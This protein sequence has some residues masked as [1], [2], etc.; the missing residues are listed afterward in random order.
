[1]LS[2]IKEDQ[3]MSPYRSRFAYARLPGQRSP[4]ECT[5]SREQ[6]RTTQETPQVGT[7]GP[8]HYVQDTMGGPRSPDVSMDDMWIYD[9]YA[10]EDGVS[11]GGY[12]RSPS[13]PNHNRTISLPTSTANYIPPNNAP[14]IREP[15]HSHRPPPLDMPDREPQMLDPSIVMAMDD[16]PGDVLEYLS[17][18][19]PVI[20]SSV[21]S[22]AEYPE[23]S[24][25]EQE[26]LSV[27]EV[28]DQLTAAALQFEHI[29]DALSTVKPGE[30]LPGMDDDVAFWIV[31]ALNL[32]VSDCAEVAV[33][34]MQ[35]GEYVQAL[36]ITEHERAFPTNVRPLPRAS[37]SER[38]MKEVMESA[39]NIPDVEVRQALAALEATT[40]TSEESRRPRER[41]PSLKLSTNDAVLL[42]ARLQPRSRLQ[43]VG[44]L[45][46]FSE[47]ETSQEKGPDDVLKKHRAYV[48]Y[49]DVGILHALQ[50]F[51]L[52][53]PILVNTH[54][55]QLVS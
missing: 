44:A 34:L 12:P 3:E 41:P 36:L 37:F 27:W 6:I 24:P 54:R 35:F 18:E 19:L 49:G 2:P 43:S 39:A 22:P 32:F 9:C 17:G 14:L 51:L 25:L 50:T 28:I 29:E 20:N 52:I 42:Q 45:G 5:I 7:K 4:S 10:S 38:D 1:M 31:E 11:P 53:A 8:Y 46:R 47:H 21:F 48:I 26:V 30:P 33:E 55:R 13:T 23:Y 15:H 16:D 40:S